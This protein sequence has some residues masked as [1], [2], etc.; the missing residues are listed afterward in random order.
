MMFFVEYTKGEKMI[1]NRNQIEQL[2]LM[3]GFKVQDISGSDMQEEY[4]LYKGNLS[5]AESGE[6]IEGVIFGSLEYPEELLD[7][8]KP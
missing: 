3:A 2:A 7:I 4:Q 1:L 6:V 8:L 5:D